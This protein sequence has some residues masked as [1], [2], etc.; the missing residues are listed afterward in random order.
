MQPGQEKIVINI[1]KE[2]F[3]KSVAPDLSQEG[4]ETFFQFANIK[5]LAQRTKSES[6]A[7]I[8]YQNDKAVGVI[9]IKDNCHIAMYF[10]KP[11]YQRKGYGKALFNQALSKIIAKRD[12]IDKIT[13]NSSLNAVS[14]YER[15]GFKIQRVR[16]F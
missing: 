11:Q 9:E 1:V 14:S 7:I 16:L 6:F 13:V 4:I 3:D 5:S 15:L 8:S 2:A 12:G 10:V